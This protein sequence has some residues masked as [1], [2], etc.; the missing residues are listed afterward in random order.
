MNPYVWFGDRLVSPI[1]R[2]FVRTTTPLTEDSKEWV[3]ISLKGRYG[4]IEYDSS[5]D[6]NNLSLDWK[7]FIYFEDSAEAM[8]Y[9]LRWA[10]NN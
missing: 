5:S 3:L 7:T 10:G 8:L 6:L 9:E 2:H 1:P 4:L